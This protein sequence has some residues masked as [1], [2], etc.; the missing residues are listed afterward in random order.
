VKSALALIA[1]IFLGVSP[2]SAEINVGYSLDWLV[3]SCPHIAVVQ[4]VEKKL[5]DRVVEAGVKSVLKGDPPRSGRFDYY[6]PSDMKLGNEFLV[7]WDA[8]KHFRYAIDLDQAPTSSFSAAFTDD[9]KVY[10]DGE[11]IVDAAKERLR[12][13]PA[14]PV[15][16]DANN[17]PKRGAICLD[18]PVDSAAWKIMWGGS[19]CYLWVPADPE[20]KPVVMK[21]IAESKEPMTKAGLIKQLYNYPDKE[22]FL[23]LDNCLRDTSTTKIQFAAGSGHQDEIVYPVRQAAYLALVASGNAPVAKPPGYSDSLS[24][25]P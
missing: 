4:R 3:D 15:R 11:D 10:T 6:T 13:K 25:F 1:L 5:P 18:V 8:N 20:L 23:F 17:R 7:F 21:L 12:H 22:T 14:G 2:A 19:A 9:F 24:I 16:V